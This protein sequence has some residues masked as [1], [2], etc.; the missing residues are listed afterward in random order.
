MIGQASRRRSWRVW[1]KSY[2]SPDLGLPTDLRRSLACT[3][4]IESMDSIIRQACRNI[5]CWRDASMVP[6][7][8]AAAGMME[9]KN[10]SA[11]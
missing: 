11:V 2:A 3:D 8:T 7:G 1:T 5:E 9:A 10:G 6:H 4:I